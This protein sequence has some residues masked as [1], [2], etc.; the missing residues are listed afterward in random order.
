MVGVGS[1][2]GVELGHHL[3]RREH[4]FVVSATMVATLSKGN[5][6]AQTPPEQVVF[7][8]AI[9]ELAISEVG[10]CKVF[11][12]EGTMAEASLY[13][14]AYAGGAVVAKEVVHV[15]SILR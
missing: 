2:H 12:A 6:N 13:H 11:G 8:V 3:D 15:V 7:G 5:I 1:T 14:V 10:V 9:E 4:V